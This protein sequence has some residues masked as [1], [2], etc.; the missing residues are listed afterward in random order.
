MK[1]KKVK[2]HF[3]NAK[4]VKCLANGNIYKLSDFK[5]LIR[6][7]DGFEQGRILFCKKENLSSNSIQDYVIVWSNKKGFAEIIS[8]KTP[9]L[10]ID[11]DLIL[12]IADKCP[13]CKDDLKKEFPGVFENDIILN[14]Y[15]KWNGQEPIIGFVDRKTNLLDCYGFK[16]TV[17]GKIEY[18]D[19]N[20]LHKSFL[21]PV[22]NEEI[23]S[24]LQK[25]AEK[26]GLV[27]GATIKNHQGTFKLGKLDIVYSEK[28]NNGI[29]TRQGKD[30]IWLFI[31]GT[32]AT[33]IQTVTQKE[34][35]D[36]YKSEKGIT[37]EIIVEG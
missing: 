11:K 19:Y 35:L 12:K 16:F 14:R 4:E 28:Y 7:K 21:E 36:F 13:S 31:N 24:A 8:Y 23:L 22:T 18:D 34:L 1:L 17:K 10:E 3:E 6:G 29:W 9:K 37:N 27:E 15:Y 30:G 5:F 20:S 26:R 33:P 2:K 25:E 32:W